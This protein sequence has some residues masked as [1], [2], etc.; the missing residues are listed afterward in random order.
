L[1]ESL[2]HL[3]ALALGRAI[4]LVKLI[5]PEPLLGRQC[6]H[7]SLCAHVRHFRAQRIDEKLGYSVGCGFV[8][9]R[10]GQRVGLYGLGLLAQD[11]SEFLDLVTR[12]AD[13]FVRLSRDD[14]V[15]WFAPLCSFRNLGGE[16][17]NKLI[18]GNSGISNGLLRR[19][20]SRHKLLWGVLRFVRGLCSG[21]GGF[22]LA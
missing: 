7:I 14:T 4:G 5:K 15:Y 13:E 3:L 21:F 1:F 10:A 8:L 18:A 9:A 16:T 22:S 17:L 19:L 12:S 2:L 11:L 20:L 6:V